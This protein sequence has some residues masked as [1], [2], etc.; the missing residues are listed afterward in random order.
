LID[1]GTLATPNTEHEK[2]AQTNYCSVSKP[3]L[4]K[5]AKAQRALARKQKGSKNRTKARLRLAKIYERLSNQRNNF[6]HQLSS[7]LIKG[8]NQTF[9]LET[10]DIQ[11]MQQN[12]QLAREIS[13]CSW[14]ELFRQIQY[15]AEWNGKN[16][17]F[18]DQFD[19]SSKTCSCCGEV[20]ELLTLADREW[21]CHH[22]NTKHDRDINAAINIKAFGLRDI[23]S[24]SNAG[25]ELSEELAESFFRNSMKQETI[26]LL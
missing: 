16:V 18:I 2:L 6:L 8:E 13:D 25:Q 7:F 19:P 23:I 14:G 15:K 20:N 1:V 17:I 26:N 3:P 21:I 4:R 9:I 22:C 11:K 24:Q 12:R 10:L 5:L